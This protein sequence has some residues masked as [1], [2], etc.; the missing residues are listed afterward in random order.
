MAQMA[1]RESSEDSNEGDRE[2]NVLTK[3]LQTKEH[4]CNPNTTKLCCKCK[5]IYFTLL[6][7]FMIKY[8]Y[9]P[10][11][12]TYFSFYHSR[13]IKMLL[14]MHMVLASSTLERG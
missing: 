2:N 11:T 5:C 6:S 14:L 3:T 8:E 13:T 4:G 9:S 1:L 12:D 10:F 7:M